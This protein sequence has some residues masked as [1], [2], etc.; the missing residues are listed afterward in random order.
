MMTKWLNVWVGN[1]CGG[2]SVE[3]F[4]AFF[5]DIMKS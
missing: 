4:G 3:M 2:P 5:W 1:E